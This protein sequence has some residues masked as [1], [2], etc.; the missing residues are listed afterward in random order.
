[1]NLKTRKTSSAPGSNS[2]RVRRKTVR[3]EESI[4]FFDL[5]GFILL[6]LLAALYCADATNNRKSLN[7]ALKGRVFLIVKNK[8]ADAKFPWFF[9]V[10]EKHDDEKMRDAAV[11]HVAAH[12]GD[13]LEVTPVGFAPIGYVKYLHDANDES[14][15][16]DGTKVFFYKSQFLMGDVQLNDA[17]AEDYLWVTRE[18]LA[19]YLSGDVADY[20]KK[21]VPN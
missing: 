4:Y 15:E 13:D 20:V 7:R 12:V 11:R 21:I 9:P 2:R 8:A 10:G 18:E 16:F 3:K 17:K 5:F 14:S 6:I 1:M 19:E